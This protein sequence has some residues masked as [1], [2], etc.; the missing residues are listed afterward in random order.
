MY[1]TIQMCRCKQWID[2]LAINSAETV[3]SLISRLTKK[4][5]ITDF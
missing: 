3:D 1:E 4:I 2:I 5:L